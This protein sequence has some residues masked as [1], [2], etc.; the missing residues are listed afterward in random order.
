MAYH[1]GS[2]LDKKLYCF[3]TCHHCHISLRIPRQTYMRS[4]N[5]IGISR[6]PNCRLITCVVFAIQEQGSTYCLVA[7]SIHG[8]VLFP[9]A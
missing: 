8:R 2:F 9:I 6:F 5:W 1:P 3:V 7:V 4:P